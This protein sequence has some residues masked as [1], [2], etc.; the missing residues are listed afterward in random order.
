MWYSRNLLALID[1]LHDRDRSL[2]PFA[3]TMNVTGVAPTIRQRNISLYYSCLQ[4]CELACE[5]SAW[6]IICADCVVSTL[7]ELHRHSYRGMSLYAHGGV[8]IIQCA[9]RKC[10]AVSAACAALSFVHKACSP[11]LLWHAVGRYFAT[12][13][14]QY[15]QHV[16]N[17]YF[18]PT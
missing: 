6:T 9:C 10:A 1:Q 5:L 16:N 7:P 2:Q 8:L 14:V 3:G 18:K 17:N 11:R 13:D 4:Q 12:H 15:Q